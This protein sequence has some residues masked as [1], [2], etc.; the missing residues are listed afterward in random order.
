MC[1]DKIRKQ[2]CA[3]R[4]LLLGLMEMDLRV[5]L[6]QAHGKSPNCSPRAESSRFR[7]KFKWEGMGHGHGGGMGG[8]GRWR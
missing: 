6:V 7:S 2:T 8:Q 3:G 4:G 5:R 1:I